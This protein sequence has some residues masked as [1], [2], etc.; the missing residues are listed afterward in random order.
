MPY[1]N[2]RSLLLRVCGNENT[3]VKPETT[4]AEL[5]SESA[6]TE[7]DFSPL[8]NLTS[9]VG[10]EQELAWLRERLLS[11]HRII[12][13]TGPGGVGKTRMAITVSELP[14]IQ[15]AFPDGVVFVPVG[16]IVD[17]TRVIPVIA[18]A[19]GVVADDR[20][21][22]ADRLIAAI[23]QQSI[24]LIVDNL[25]HVIE[26]SLSLK[27]LVDACPRLTLLVTSRRA[28][29]VTGEQEF[30][31]TSLPLPGQGTQLIEEMSASPSVRLFVDR[32]T[33]VNPAF[34]LNTENAAAVIEIC[35]RLDGLPLAIE[36]AATRTKMLSVQAL[37]SRLTG[38]LYLL[39]SGPRDAP[40]RQQTLRETIRWSYDLLSPF[41]QLVFRR[42]AVFSG[43]ATLEA[44]AAIAGHGVPVAEFELLDVVATLVEQSL[45]IRE[46]MPGQQVR[47][48]MLET[49]REFALEQLDQEEDADS[50]RDAHAVY[51]LSVAEYAASDEYGHDES[52]RILALEPD[53]INVRL[54]LGWLLIDREF[55]S[56]HVHLGLRLAGAMTRYWD[57]RGFV[58]EERE[59]RIHA[60]STVPEEPTAERG[61][62]LTGLGVN[63]WF[64]S[65]LA[66]AEDWQRQALD[67]WR[68]L[69]DPANIV[70]SLWFLAI[71]AGKRADI[72]RLE[73]LQAEAETVS[74]RIPGRIWF[75]VPVAIRALIDLVQGDGEAAAHHL[76]IAADYHH[77]HGNLWPEAWTVGLMADAALIRGDR[78]EAMKLMQQS[79]ELFS[80]TGDVYAMLDGLLSIALHRAALG[81]AEAATRMLGVVVRVRRL[82]GERQ[83]WRVATMESV[84]SAVVA[85]LGEER[86]TAILR[87]S[88][89]MTL[90]DGVE[91]ALSGVSNAAGAQLPAQPAGGFNLSRRE[92]EILR[93]LTQGKTNQE[94][95]DE[96]FISHRTAGTHVANILGKLGVHSRAAAVSVALN[97]QLV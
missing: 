74:P 68:T 40:L 34:V 58:T 55:D 17:S 93:L 95:G 77:Q 6:V 62:A 28:M 54:A 23:D 76:R 38:R 85:A 37:A 3:D 83:T 48:R 45:L 29:R 47:F 70:R 67:V 87:D 4:E 32:A 16:H 2:R 64:C 79:L 43:G 20:V 50:I 86:V 11:A 49:I 66:E 96:L 90:H 5:N 19:M 57:T 61:T 82:V 80:R 26:A 97:N 41:E 39:T 15:A 60:L 8:M 42:L 53:Q 51:F 56:P 21:S 7:S 46:E 44:I 25:E 59:W 92:L 31:L 88:A 24:L 10:R 30:S 73:E 12:T 35:N 78:A 36:L 1:T 71:V 27:Q 13:I 65:K 14:E 81:D 63:A 72:P 22:A 18:R 94:I 52:T 75:I 69:D 84:R 9:F 33:A 89:A 91:I